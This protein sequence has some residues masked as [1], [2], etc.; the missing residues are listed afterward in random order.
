MAQDNPSMA[1][2]LSR[3]GFVLLFCIM[4]HPC[5]YIAGM[6]K[7]STKQLTSVL[8]KILTDIEERIER[9]YSVQRVK[10][11]NSTCVWK[12]LKVAFT[13]SWST[14]IH[15]LLEHGYFNQS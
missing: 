11:L 15:Q 1:Y 5:Q 6:I 2:Y 10:D 12:T 14:F 8:T 9:Y 4:P 3:E 7:D 13:S